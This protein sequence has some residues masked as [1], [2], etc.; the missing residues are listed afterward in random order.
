MPRTPDQKAID[1]LLTLPNTEVLSHLRKRNE[2]GRM[3][4][5]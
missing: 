1:L 3:H 5:Q 2:Q 4:W